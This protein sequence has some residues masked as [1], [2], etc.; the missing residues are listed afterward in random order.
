MNEGE[1]DQKGSGEYRS[2]DEAQMCGECDI[3]AHQSRI[4]AWDKETDAVELAQ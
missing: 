4:R 3:V 2:S 1:K